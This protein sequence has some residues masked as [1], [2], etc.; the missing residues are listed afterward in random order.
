MSDNV[1]PIQTTFTA[2]AAPPAA[3]PHADRKY[4]STLGEFSQRAA[5]LRNDS[6]VSLAFSI[7]DEALRRRARQMT[8]ATY[9]APGEE[10]FNASPSDIERAWTHGRPRL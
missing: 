1:D 6:E 10:P 5:K 4:L 7:L 3:N 8:P 9:P 2:N